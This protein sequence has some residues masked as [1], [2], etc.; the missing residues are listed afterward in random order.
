VAARLEVGAREEVHEAEPARVII[1][2]ARAV[3]ERE[4]DV[5]VRPFRAR[6][7]GI[8]LA[9]FRGHPAT[10][11]HEEAAGHAEVHDQDLAGGE[12]GEEV[13]GAASQRQDPLPREPLCEIRGKRIAQVRPAQFDA[14]EQGSRHHGFQATADGLDLGKLG[15]RG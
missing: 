14:F 2:D 5:V 10:I 11:R 7:G 4:D 15:H 1:G 8:E 6:P 13:F 9:G 12:V 3:R